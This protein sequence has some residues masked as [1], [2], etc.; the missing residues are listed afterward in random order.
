MIVIFDLDLAVRDSAHLDGRG[1]LRWEAVDAEVEA[2]CWMGPS[3]VLISG[4]PDE[5]AFNDDGHGLLPGE[6]GLWSIDDEAWLFRD[7]FSGHTGTVHRL[8]EQLVSLYGHPKLID[9]RT[10]SVVA[11]WPELKSGLQT[12]SILWT[13]QPEPFA[14]DE[15]NRRFAVAN[16]ADI[17]VVEVD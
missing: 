11:E 6:V 7:M 3:T 16:G 10:L 17:T 13:Q 9:P 2:A 8:G 14:L 5:E 15:A 4:N 12:S 1:I